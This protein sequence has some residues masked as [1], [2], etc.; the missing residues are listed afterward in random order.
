MSSSTNPAFPVGCLLMHIRL[1]T[2]SHRNRL[3]L[4]P[5]SIALLPIGSLER[6]HRQ[7]HARRRPCPVPRSFRMSTLKC[8][9]RR[10]SRRFRMRIRSGPCEAMWW[11]IPTRTRFLR[12]T[13]EAQFAHFISAALKPNDVFWDVGAHF[14]YYTLLVSRRLTTGKCLSFEPDPD[15]RWYLRHHISWNELANVTVFP[16]AV[17][18]TD[19][20]RSFG[21]GGT[22]AGKLDGGNLQVQTRSID[23]LVESGT[24]PAPTFMKIDTEGAEVEV[25]SG[26]VLEGRSTVLCIAT[27]GQELHAECKRRTEAMGYDVHDF[28]ADSLVIA[29]P[30]GRII[31]ESAWRH[32]AP[33]NPT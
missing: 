16:W 17:A 4:Q 33:V 21:G 25:L 15:N 18:S 31:A 14:G 29:V 20:T 6:F 8:F 5:D 26:K 13:Y 11:S 3:P 22:G 28:P 32:L 23:S 10:L 24:C 19:A 27:H 1:R 9:V 30:P 2:Q 7:D 12:G